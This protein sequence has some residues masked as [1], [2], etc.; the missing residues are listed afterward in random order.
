MRFSEARHSEGNIGALRKSQPLI[1]VDPSC[2]TD[3]RLHKRLTPN[4]VVCYFHVCVSTN[5]NNNKV[6]QT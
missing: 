6:S 2:W 3:I 4:F 5:L 1:K